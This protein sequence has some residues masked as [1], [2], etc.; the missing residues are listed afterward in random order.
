MGPKSGLITSQRGGSEVLFMLLRIRQENFGTK[1]HENHQI[2]ALLE[3]RIRRKASAKMREFGFGD[4]V[5]L[6]SN[7]AGRTRLLYGA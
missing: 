4:T 6:R 7:A 2:S 3:F 5:F 1:P